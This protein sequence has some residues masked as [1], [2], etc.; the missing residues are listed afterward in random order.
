MSARKTTEAPWFALPMDVSEAAPVRRLC[1]I[2]RKP[3]AWAH[4]F[5]A[6]VDCRRNNKRRTFIGADARDTFE[7]AARWHGRRG[8][9]AAVAVEV[10]ILRESGAGLYLLS[11][12]E[13]MAGN[14]WT[15]VESPSVSDVP[16]DKDAE[17]RA[18]DRARKARNRTDK[19]RNSSGHDAELPRNSAD[20]STDTADKSAADGRFTPVSASARTHETET[21]TETK[22][23]TEEQ[24]HAPNSAAAQASLPTPPAKPDPT[25]AAITEVLEHWRDGVW[26]PTDGDPKVNIEGPKSEGRRKLI[27]PLLREG[28]TVERLKRVVDGAASDDWL[29][30]RA[31]GAKQGGWTEVENV[32]RRNRLDAREK[33]ATAP[34]PVRRKDNGPTPAGAFDALWGDPAGTEGVYP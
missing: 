4:L 25:E 9:L 10:G 16:A 24:E 33:A 7:D 23:E 26:V 21:K 31:P 32:F 15:R 30:G 28:W 19:A 12:Q 14:D 18:K 13:V 2:L 29:M 17:R 20:T 3:E 5:Y 11:E 6:W 22:T 1:V 34:A 8:R 27:R